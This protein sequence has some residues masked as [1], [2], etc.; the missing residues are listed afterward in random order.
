MKIKLSILIVCTLIV[1]SLCYAANNY[2]VTTKD[3]LSR[4][5]RQNLSVFFQKMSTCQS[6]QMTGNTV[7]YKVRKSGSYCIY[8]E[9]NRQKTMTCKFPL[10]VAK[11]YA[12]NGLKF[13]NKILNNTVS[14]DMFG[15]REVLENIQLASKYCQ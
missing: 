11:T 4:T 12:E 5:E 1:C 10:S 6:A 3:N 8:E 14:N 15:D 13:N 9:S 2:K 7:S